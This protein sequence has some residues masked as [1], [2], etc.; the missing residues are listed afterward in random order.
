MHAGVGSRKR[1]IAGQDGLGIRAREVHRAGVA[2]DYMVEGIQGRDRNAKA[3][4]R[5]AAGG[6][7]GAEVVI[8]KDPRLGA[9]QA[10]IG[11]K[12]QHVVRA[13]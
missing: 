3:G 4:A 12:E 10:V 5:R 1:V 13:G 11:G 7:G 2:R 8:L 6:S 9:M